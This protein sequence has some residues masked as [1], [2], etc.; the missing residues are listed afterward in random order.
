MKIKGVFLVL[1]LSIQL[2]TVGQPSGYGFGKR[3]TINSS[4]I[5]G[6]LDLINFPI[7]IN[8]SDLN[9]RTT[10]NG[11]RLE[12]N[13]GYDIVFTLSDCSTILDHQIEKYDSITGDY[14]AWV[15]IPVLP[16]NN[17]TVIHMYY[18][19]SSVVSNPSTT[20]T[21][22]SDFLGIWHMAE[23]PSGAAPQ[24]LDATSGGNNGT[25]N[26]VMTS[27]DLVDGKCGDALDFDGV[28]DYI[29]FGDI[30]IDGLTSITVEA[31]IN[32]QSL[33][34]K[35]SPS[36]HNSNEGA[37]IHKN[38]AS[39]DNLGVTVTTGGTAFYLDDG[40][41]NTPLATSPSLNTWVHIVCTWDRDTM[42]VYLD[43]TL[44]ATLGNVNGTLVNN[45]NSLR[46]G[47]L[48]G[49]GGGNPHEFDG[50][51][52]EVRLSDVARTADWIKTTFNNHNIPDSFISISSESTASTLCPP[53]PAELID[54]SGYRKLSQVF[55]QWTTASELNNNY[56][57][58][59]RSMDGSNWLPIDTI[60]GAGTSSSS[61]KYQAIDK[62][63]S[64]ENLYYRLQQTD[65]DGAF[66]YSSILVIKGTNQN[67]QA[68]ILIYPNPSQQQI[69]LNF[70]KEKTFK[71]KIYNSLGKDMTHKVRILSSDDESTKIDISSLSI[72][73]YTIKIDGK[74]G[75]FIK[76]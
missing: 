15:R 26:G 6:N 48:H 39:D 9:L 12:N 37:I 70:V 25:S 67:E 61:I 23:D 66:S 58:L 72:G 31:W 63:A 57:T 54:F 38:G 47:G 51:I 16:A 74:S 33:R 22:D 41:N 42:K 50:L 34:T 44:D 32:A 27:G 56:F 65:Y 11:G 18:G 55:L 8:L 24:I 1:L 40:G 5:S 30:L 4:Q 71:P 69:T 62:Y 53:V 75:R 13:S 73:C 7:L 43:G 36:G 21:W 3:I 68:I 52:D 19:N 35:G 64:E 45:T 29:D 17:D 76:Q 10:G 20:S 60:K 59:Y 49:A 46:L 2:V 28:N 14:I